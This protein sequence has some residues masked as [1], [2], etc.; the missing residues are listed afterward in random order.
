MAA[1][2][3]QGE[4]KLLLIVALLLADELEEARSRAPDDAGMN[5]TA[6]QALADRLSDLAARLA[7][8]PAAS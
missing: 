7:S 1:L 5:E 3:P 6:V 2:G 8:E 4:A